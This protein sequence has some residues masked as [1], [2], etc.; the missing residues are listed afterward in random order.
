[1]QAQNGSMLLEHTLEAA[2]PGRAS[3]SESLEG[4][5]ERA[6]GFH[7]AVPQTLAQTGLPN[8]L[9]EQLILKFLY[10]KGE[11]MARDLCGLMGLRFSL[12]EA[13]IEGLKAQLLIQVKSSLGYGP[14]SATLALTDAGRRVTRDYLDTNQYVG[15]APVPVSQ[16][17]NAVYAQRM[18]SKWLTRE[19]LA[20]AYSQLVMTDAIL[21]QIG[22]AVASGKSF[23]IYGQPGNGK[24]QIAEALANVSSSDLYVPYALECQGNIVQLYDPIYHKLADKQTEAIHHE[25]DGRWARCKRPFIA[26][27]G[28]LSVSMLDL[29]FNRI[30]KIYDAPFQLKANNGIY[31]IDDFGRQKASAGEILNRWIVPMERRVDYLSFENGGKMTVPFET[32]LVFS[33]NLTPDKLGDEAFLRRIQYKMLLRSPDQKEFRTIFSAFA[34]RQG[35]NVS[36]ELL[37]RFIDKHYARTGK[38]FRRC[39][40]RDV[41]SQAIDYIQFKRLPYELTEELLD[42]AFASCFPMLTDLSE[43]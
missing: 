7:P 11:L 36:R 8:A 4:E 13:M 41:I 9:I 20:A 2:G 12:V 43:A 24:T 14:V 19:R 26:T 42:S 32:F 22:P 3:Q 40:A 16:Y 10:F 38:Q 21:D 23:L 6:N 17:T 33:T 25:Y 39:H 31:L 18:P 34:S 1:M 35:L 29:G 15:P 28:E 5:S 37:D 30:S 27:G